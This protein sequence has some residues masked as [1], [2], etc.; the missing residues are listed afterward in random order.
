MRRLI[1]TLP[2]LVACNL[3]EVSLGADRDAGGSEP[4]DSGTTPADRDAAATRDG[5]AR[6]AAAPDGSV[7]TVETVATTTGAPLRAAID[8]SFIYWTEQ[9][10][11]P[12]TGRLLKA[13]LGGGS[14]TVLASTL[15]LP[16]GVAVDG[17]QAFVYE[18]GRYDGALSPDAVIA[19]GRLS[20]VP[21][22]GGAINVLVDAIPHVNSGVGHAGTIYAAGG[23]VFYGVDERAPG[24][25]GLFRVSTSGG[26]ST[27]VNVLAARAYN[28]CE[29]GT[30]LFFA[31]GSLAFALPI[32]GGTSRVVQ[33]PGSRPITQSGCA[34][35]TGVVT[36]GAP[37]GTL[38]NA[39]FVTALAYDG[40]TARD[41]TPIESVFTSLAADAIHV[42]Y[43]DGGTTRTAGLYRAPLSGG[44]GELL[45]PGSVTFIV[46]DATHVYWGTFGSGANAVHR[47][48][49]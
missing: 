18:D 12:S 49:K 24:G 45:A 1:L 5:S 9:G 30:D 4:G 11:L 10:G 42:Y 31:V 43:R 47:L 37:S 44:A 25:G 39:G 23:N 13:P 2:L 38:A 21:A 26:A 17:A 6:D 46:L 22:S 33:E 27:K 34:P 3:G 7:A 8:S 16:I 19:E 36:I 20:A 32:A 15:R 29:H 40:A 28:I 35:T 41:I 14:A 48:R